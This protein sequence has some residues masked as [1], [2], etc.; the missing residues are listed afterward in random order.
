MKKQE[1]TLE[2]QLYHLG[3]IVLLT[4]RSVN[5]WKTYFFS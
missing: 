3:W 1:T 5:R 2:T 4:V